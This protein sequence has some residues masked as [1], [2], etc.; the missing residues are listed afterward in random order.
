M[1]KKLL[2]RQKIQW[3]VD[4]LK[5]LY[6]QRNNID[7]PE[8]I[9]GILFAIFYILILTTIFSWAGYYLFVNKIS[10]YLIGFI[11]ACYLLSYLKKIKK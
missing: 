3:L 5:K 6:E 4:Y 7:W 9:T 2:I 8:K 10:R 1:E 11:T